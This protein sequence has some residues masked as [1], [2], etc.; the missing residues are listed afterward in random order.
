MSEAI[1]LAVPTWNF[2]E[3]TDSLVGLIEA[4][5]LASPSP[6]TKESVAEVLAHHQ[7]IL[8]PKIIQ[9]AINSLLAKHEGAMGGIQLTEV[10][11][12][13]AFRTN[14]RYGLFIRTLFKEKPQKLSN[15]Q[16]EV[17][18]II[19]Y[20]QPV[21]RTEIEEIR[22]VDCSGSMRKLLNVKLIKILGKSHGIGRPLLYG[23]TKEF[24]E[25]FGLNSLHDL[26]TLREYEELN[27]AT[28][29]KEAKPD[30]HETIE[31]M[32]LFEGHDLAKVNYEERERMSR[33]ALETLDKA[34]HRVANAAEK[35]EIHA[36]T[37]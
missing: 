13:L 18:S 6:V 20:R 37:N 34:L 2:V 21:T 1:E 9:A 17:L 11:G 28:D 16:L 7:I 32:D 23:T 12:G 35:L 24:L 10:A 29:A 33:E 15:S 25:F 26:P 27:K 14:A 22:G 3:D 30:P 8:E 5:A 19:S 4:L 36:S 31:M